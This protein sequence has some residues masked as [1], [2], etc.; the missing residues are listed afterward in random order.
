M[1]SEVYWPLG[2]GS[3]VSRSLITPCHLLRYRH[4]C[5]VSFCMQLSNA[6]RH[7]RPFSL[8]CCLCSPSPP[9]SLPIP[10]AA[11]NYHLSHRSFTT[12]WHPRRPLVSP[13]H[14]APYVRI[15]ECHVVNVRHFAA[16]LPS[17][18]THPSYQIF[19][20]HLLDSCGSHATC[21][22]I[23]QSYRP[24]IVSHRWWLR[25]THRFR[26]TRRQ[27]DGWIY[28]LVDH[29][30]HVQ[31]RRPVCLVLRY[32]LSADHSTIVMSSSSYRRDVL[33]LH[34]GRLYTGSGY[35]AM[36]MWVIWLHIYFQVPIRAP[37]S[38]R[39]TGSMC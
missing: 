1:V 32:P 28:W 35:Y 16:F 36:E 23:Y 13:T 17:A 6:A 14:T 10:V 12:V 2:E 22:L 21:Q 8:S 9:C 18:V 37:I 3:L 39:S 24:T 27:M 34:L 38:S 20:Q 26:V 30:K 29:A 25:C 7:V 15:I 4:W 19:I 5:S 33:D 11:C 31:A